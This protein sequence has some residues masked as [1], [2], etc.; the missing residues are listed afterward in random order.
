MPSIRP[1]IALFTLLIAGLSQPAAALCVSAAEAHLREGPGKHYRKTWTVY[2]YMP[3]QSLGNKG[4]WLKVKD[5]DGERHWIHASL[6]ST[7]MGCAAVKR[8]NANVRTGPGTQ[9]PRATWS[10]LDRYYSL[11]VLSTKG[12][13][14]QVRDEVGNTGWVASA[15]LWSLRAGR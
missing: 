6:V 8:A 5:L 12:R 13:W 1:C 11:K 14:T 2:Q 7:R 9:Y 3:L 15:L 4:R 10:P